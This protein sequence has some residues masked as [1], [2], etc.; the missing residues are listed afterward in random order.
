MLFFDRYH[1]HERFSSLEHRLHCLTRKSRRKVPVIARL[2]EHS[3]TRGEL[4]HKY[5]AKLS[6]SPLG[7]IHSIHRLLVVDFE[8]TEISKCRALGAEQAHGKSKVLVLEECKVD[9]AQLLIAALTH[10]RVVEVGAFPAVE[11]AVL[12]TYTRVSEEEDVR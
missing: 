4:E 7:R 10:P 5:L 12:L 11:V 2:A 9:V 3:P 6:A 1:V 8:L